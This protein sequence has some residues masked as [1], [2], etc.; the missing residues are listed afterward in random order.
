MDKAVAREGG[1]RN[2]FTF[3][4]WTTYFETM[5]ADKI[6]LALRIEADRMQHSL[7]DAKELSSERTVVI[8]EREGHENEPM[9]V[10]GE[11]VQHAAFRVHSVSS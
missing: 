3:L 11:A 10:L 4:D 2:A 1:T 7:F 6:D 5:P 9:F 8:S